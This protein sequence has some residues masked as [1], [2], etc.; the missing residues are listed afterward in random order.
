MKP[1]ICAVCRCR[2]REASGFRTVR[3]ANYE[4]LPDGM[5]GHPKGLHWFCGD[6]VEAAQALADKP[7]AEARALLR[8][9]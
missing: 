2:S 3:F 5:V 8:D 9:G 4:P 6:H 1:P 7:W